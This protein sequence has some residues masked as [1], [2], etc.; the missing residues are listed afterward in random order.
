MRIIKRKER[1]K[2][3]NKHVGLLI[4]GIAI[5]LAII[6][7]LHPVIAEIAMATSSIS[8]V[9]NANLLRRHKI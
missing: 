5:L 8:V 4:I 7:I 6:G 9:T 2:M 3:E 1:T